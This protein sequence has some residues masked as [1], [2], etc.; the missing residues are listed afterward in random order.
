MELSVDPVDGPADEVP[1]VTINGTTPDATVRLVVEATDARGHRWRSSTPLRADS[2]GRVRSDD[3]LDDP[4]SPWWSMQLVAGA[5]DETGSVAPAL[6]AAPPDLLRYRVD[7]DPGTGP[8]CEVV[9][10][11]APAGAVTTEW[12]GD[13]VRT[14]TVRP[15]PGAGRWR[16][17]V[18]VLV[19][20]THGPAAMLPAAGLLATHGYVATVVHYLDEPALAPAPHEVPLERLAAGLQAAADHATVGPE[21]GAGAVAVLAASVGSEGVLATLAAFDE[22]PCEAL[23]AIA[24]SSV[25]WQALGDGGRLPDTSSWTL[26]GTPLPWVPLRRDRLFGPAAPHA[27]V[28]RLRR[29]RGRTLSQRS[30][31]AAALAR[32][33]GEAEIA[34]ERIDAPLLLLAGEDDQVWPSVEMATRLLDRRARA[35]DRLLAF[36]DAGHVLQPP[37]TPT[38]VAA[39]DVVV[40]GGTPA[41][42]ARAQAEGWHAILDFLSLHVG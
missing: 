9:R 17:V 16:S 34:A 15:A 11:W 12:S 40:S 23:V 2:A 30:A 8:A 4:S 29:R 31:Y 13:G 24:P 6:F 41:G 20:G 14:V 1:L 22:L 7:V 39:D 3:A 27:M 21:V 33:P 18:V 19:P 10:R 25:V 38:T 42:N 28:D 26:R 37:L 5:E 35:E 32:H 36:P